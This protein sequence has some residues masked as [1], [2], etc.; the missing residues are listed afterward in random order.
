MLSQIPTQDAC[1]SCGACCAYFRVSFYWAE[2]L[3][4]PDHYTQ[5]V[6]AVYSCMT[7]THQKSPRCIALTGEIGK[8]VSWGMY[9]ARSSSC[10]E[11]K[12]ADEQC[13][14]AR[15]AYT[16]IPFIPLETAEQSND[17]F[18]QVV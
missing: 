8:Q 2:G 13:N 4:M 17:D 1:L 5:P 3:A 18:D 11:V 10:K 9:Q 14:K 12:I 16:M 7:G 6:T 15:R